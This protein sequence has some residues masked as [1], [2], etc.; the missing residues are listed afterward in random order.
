MLTGSVLSLTEQLIEQFSQQNMDQAEQSLLGL[1]ITSNLQSLNEHP[2]ALQSHVQLLTDT[3]KQTINT[4]DVIALQLSKLLDSVEEQ[5]H[6]SRL[7]DSSAWSNQQTAEESNA[8]PP[9]HRNDKAP[10]DLDAVED[11]GEQSNQGMG[12]AADKAKPAQENAQQR[13]PIDDQVSVL[14]NKLSVERLFR[15]LAAVL[16]PDKELDDARRAEKHELMSFCLKARRDKDINTLL[17]LYCE[18][19][20]E[21]PDDI[22]ENTHNELISALETQLKELQSTLRA[23]QFGNS[24]NAMIVDRYCA[25]DPIMCKKLIDNHAVSLDDEIRLNKNLISQIGTCE[26]LLICLNDR[27]SVE[28]DR[29]AIHELTGVSAEY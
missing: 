7:I 6:A 26:G 9:T 17:E 27:R 2:F 16:H 22:N 1:W 5:S 10:D 8:Q 3:W 15:Q 19:L 12:G 25:S 23:E 20:G 29:L 14:E 21:L 11:R 18:H 24:L 28:Q 13:R 4:D